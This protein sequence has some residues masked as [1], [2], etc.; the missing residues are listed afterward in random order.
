MEI[1]ELDDI[2]WRLD[3]MMRTSPEQIRK[4]KPRWKQL[5]QTAT[6]T[7]RVLK[8]QKLWWCEIPQ[9]TLLELSTQQSAPFVTLLIG[10]A[11]RKYKASQISL[12]L[13]WRR[14]VATGQEHILSY[15]SWKR[16]EETFFGKCILGS[17]ILR[18]CT[19]N[20][21]LLNNITA[22]LSDDK[23]VDFKI[24]ELLGGLPMQAD[25]RKAWKAWALRN[26][27]DKGGDAETFLKVKLVYDEWNEIQ[28]KLN[29]NS[30][31]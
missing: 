5:E 28:N 13:W 30:Q 18:V 19:D 10:L 3:Q 25:V 20:E 27:P 6:N 16:L 21:A 1:G 22:A 26:H 11:E 9:S 14:L 31:E 8:L 2:F 29:N 24:R 23:T 7:A 4:L 17:D 12:L 15:F